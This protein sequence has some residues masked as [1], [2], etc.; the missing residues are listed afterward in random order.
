[1]AAGLVM[2]GVALGNLLVQLRPT[3]TADTPAA[4][5][6]A[7]NPK[8][9]PAVV[10]P[11]VSASTGAAASGTVVFRIQPWGEI[12]ID[13]KPTGVSPPLVQ[14][15]LPVGRHQIEVR[16]DNDKPWIQEIDVEAAVPVSL[17]HRFE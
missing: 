9:D 12:L 17:T 6:P 1:M 15:T 8:A 3:P 14:M 4:E 7:A 16:H 11:A 2:A 13:K 5:Q 10:S